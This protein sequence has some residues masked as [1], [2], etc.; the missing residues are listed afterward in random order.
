M[1]AGTDVQQ[2]LWN[3]ESTSLK[4]EEGEPPQSVSHTLVPEVKLHRLG[5]G[6]CVVGVLFLN[7]HTTTTYCVL[8]SCLSGVVDV[9]MCWSHFHP[10]AF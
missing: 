10:A 2:H 4:Q 1:F 6:L 9:F 8:Y 7:M 3:Q 5:K